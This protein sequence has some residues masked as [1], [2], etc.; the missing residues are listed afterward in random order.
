MV[1]KG[2][3]AP[4]WVRERRFL[5]QSE[6]P[7]SSYNWLCSKEKTERFSQSVE[8]F[9]KGLEKYKGTVVTTTGHSLGG[10]IAHAP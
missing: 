10:S 1:S 7:R 2:A 6:A 3:H 5:R 8:L 9:G 4:W